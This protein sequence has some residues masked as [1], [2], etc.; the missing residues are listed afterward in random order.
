MKNLITASGVGLLATMFLLLSQAAFT[1]E[2][3]P[4][5]SDA[6]HDTRAKMEKERREQ[7][8]QKLKDDTAKL[9]EAVDE[10]KAMIEKSNK[11]TFSIQ[12]VKKAEE[13]ERIVKDVKRRAKEGF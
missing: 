10:L 12:I 8:W 13:V 2:P 6:N 9:V 5:L 7:E 1:Q 4:D 11:D 3:R